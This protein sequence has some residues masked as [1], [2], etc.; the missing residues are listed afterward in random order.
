[1]LLRRLNQFFRRS[2]IEA[3]HHNQQIALL[4]DEDWAI[5]ARVFISSRIVALRRGAFELAVALREAR[6]IDLGELLGG[7]FI[8]PPRH[9]KRPMWAEEFGSA[10]FT[11]LRPAA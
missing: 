3:L 6:G 7:L 10:G 9:V 1:M 2:L 5:R 8:R 4:C 11:P